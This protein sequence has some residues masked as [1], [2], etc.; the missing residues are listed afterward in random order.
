MSSSSL[1]ATSLWLATLR[2]AE[3]DD[4]APAAALVNALEPGSAYARSALDEMR[5]L[6]A[7]HAGVSSAAALSAMAARNADVSDERC[8]NGA[9]DLMRRSYVESGDFKLLEGFFQPQFHSI[10]GDV[11]SGERAFMEPQMFQLPLYPKPFWAM[12]EH[13]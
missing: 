10:A 1:P 8:V 9:I 11:N 7:R 12:L 5:S 6:N 4:I 13:P 2:A 3:G